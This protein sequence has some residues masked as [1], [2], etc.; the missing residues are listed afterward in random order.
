MPSLSLPTSVFVVVISALLMAPAHASSEA[1]I[2]LIKRVFGGL[3]NGSFTFVGSGA[4]TGPESITVPSGQAKPTDMSQ[5]F[6]SQAGTAV[7]TETGSTNS[8]I[9]DVTCKGYNQGP[10]GKPSTNEPFTNEPTIAPDGRSFSIDVVGGDEVDC[11]VINSPALKPHGTLIV[12]KIGSPNTIPTTFRFDTTVPLP[13]GG[14]MFFLNVV[15]PT[16]NEVT[17]NRIPIGSYSITEAPTSGWQLSKAPTCSV[18]GEETVGA[19]TGKVELAIRNGKTTTC[20]FTNHRSPHVSLIKRIVDPSGNELAISVPEPFKFKISTRE[21][22][23]IPVVDGSGYEAFDDLPLGKTLIRETELPSNFS[24]KDATCVVNGE[25]AGTPISLGVELTLNVGDLVTCTFT[26]ILNPPPPPPVVNLIVRKFADDKSEAT[27]TFSAPR[28]APN[29]NF[30]LTTTGGSDEVTFRDLKTGNYTITEE[31]LQ[32]WQLRAAE[33]FV[34]EKSD[35]NTVGAFDPASRT[36]GLTIVPVTTPTTITCEFFN[37]KDEVVA[38]PEIDLIVRKFADDKSEATFTFSAPRIAPNGNFQLTTTGG[39]DEVT[40]RDLKTGSYTITEEAL[41]GWQLRAAECFVGEESDG[42]TVGAFDPASRTVGLTI[43][44]ANTPTTI[45]CEFFNRRIDDRTTK[46]IRN[47]LFR[48]AEQLTG[49]TG[50]PRLIE[51]R[52]VSRHTSLK[53]TLGVEGEGSLKD[54]SASYRTSLLETLGNQSAGK[55]ERMGINPSDYG[56]SSGPTHH[57]GGWDLWSEGRLSYFDTDASYDGTKSSGRFGLVRIGADYLVSPSFLVGILSQ[58]DYL[59]E[60]ADNAGT[61]YKISGHGFMVGPYAEYELTKGLYFDAKAL[62]GTSRNEISPFNTFTD[63]FDTTRWLLA[64]RL[65]GSWHYGAWH[66]SPRAEIAYFSE[67]SQSFTDSTGRPVAGQK[68]NLG[69]F[70]IGPELA[71]RHATDDGMRIEPRVAIKGLWAFGTGRAQ[72]LDPGFSS[73]VSAR[74][75]DDFQLQLG[76]GLIIEL[77]SGLRM[78][79]EG[80]YTG[81]GESS[82]RSVSGKLNVTVPLQSDN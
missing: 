20:I 43:V 73:S 40:F 13:D 56:V 28:I 4:I 71:Y 19:D 14:T 52:R 54:G 36:I 72:S 67:T 37:R 45:T 15:G 5:T 32:G 59:S 79:L 33:C 48:R 29:G 62:G 41:Q 75:V 60:E 17:L 78:D 31:A 42:N 3:Q 65:T 74:P 80:G 30:Q 23:N 49:D 6:T 77:P 21:P 57:S 16:Y 10:P 46:I 70:K 7:I 63:E 53:D 22:F 55:A 9:I 34:G 76:G 82:N 66:I 50:R 39:S 8:R 35:G 44:P 26:N 64:A 2:T 1:R 58:Y 12:Q 68:V 24:F 27:F 18:D 51:R 81:F 61:G 25:T 69:R 47:F 38:D 11:N